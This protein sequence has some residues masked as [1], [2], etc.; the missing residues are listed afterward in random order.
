MRRIVLLIV[1]FLSFLG[2]SKAQDGGIYGSFV[3]ID[4]NYYQCKDGNNFNG[5][6]FG[7]FIEGSSLLL[8][9]GELKTWKKNQCDI[10]GAF[11]YY[12]IYKVG[13]TPSNFIEINLPWKQNGIDGNGNNQKWAKTDL[14]TNVLSGLSAGDYTIEVY[15]K[16]T[17][18]QGDKYDGNGGA[19]YKATLKV[20]APIP[21]SLQLT[22]PTP[23]KEDNLNNAV[24]NVILENE[25]FKDST[26]DKANFILEN[27][28]NGIT[29]KSV[30]YVDDKNAKVTLSF[31]GT[32]FDADVTNFGLTV[33]KEE[34][35]QNNTDLTKDNLTITAIVEDELKIG[36]VTI[37]PSKP[38]R[39]EQV[40]ITLDA[41]GTT[42]EDATKVYFHS[43]V[44]MDKPNSKQF[45]KVKG[46]WNND[47]G[48]GEMTSLGNHKWQIVLPSIDAY[49]SLTNNDD[50]FGLNFLFRNADGTKEKKNG[51]E[52]YHIEIEAGNYFIVTEPTSSPH[53]VEKGVSFPIKANA[54]KP[55]NWTLDEL[56]S[57]GT[58]K[59]ANVNTQ[60]NIEDYTFNHS[61]NDENVVHYFKL[62]ADFG[63]G[64]TK[65][66]TFEVKTHKAITVAPLPNGAKKGVNYNDDGT[67][68]F[69]LHTPTKT[70]YGYYGYNGNS[71]TADSSV[72]MTKAKKVVYLIGDFNNWTANDTY[73][74]NRTEDSDYWHI[75]LTKEQLKNLR[76]TGNKQSVFQYL[77]DGDIRIGDPYTHQ[78]SDYDDKYIIEKGI[79]PDLISYPEGKTTGRASVV[80]LENPTDYV[81]K[82]PVFERKKERNELNVYEL[83]FRD[84][85][86]EGTYKSAIAKLDYLKELGIN[87]IHVMPISEFEGNDSWG[88]NPN[89]YF[90][91]DKAYGTPND[92]KEF[93]D[94]AHQRGIAV[95]NDLVLNHAFSSNPN[96]MLYWNK[97]ENR[98]A[99]DNPWFN[100]QHKGIPNEGGHW[101]ADWNHGSEHTR[102]MVDDI[103]NYWMNEFHFD[104]FRFDFTKGLTQRDPNISGDWG[105]NYDAC[106]IEILKRMANVV[107]ANT[108]GTG[109]NPYVIFEHLAND[110]EDKE[111]ADA[112][113]LLWSGARTQT[114]YMEMAMG[115][116]IESFWNSVYKSREFNFAN[117]MSYLE[118]H[119]EERIGYKVKKW[120][121]NNDGTTKYLINRLKLVATFNMLLPGPRM[122]WQF[123]ELGYDKSIDENGRTGKKTNAWDLNYD[124][125]A[126]RQQLY[127]LYSLIFKLRNDY[128]F[129]PTESEPQYDNIG[130]TTDWKRKMRFWAPVP[131]NPTL[132]KTVQIIPVGNFDT[133]NNATITPEYDPNLTG[134]WFKYNGDPAVDGTPYQVN[135]VSDTYDLKTNDPVYILTNADLIPPKI[136]PITKKVQTGVNTCYIVPD[137]SF[138]FVKDTYSQTENPPAG[139]ASDNDEV[140]LY[141]TSINGVEVT[142]K[143]TFS[144]MEVT[145][146][147]SLQGKE[148][149]QGK[150]TI[151]WVAMDNFGNKTEVDQIIN[152]CPTSDLIIS[153]YVEPKKGRDKLVEIYNGTCEDI[154]LSNYKLGIYK[155]GNVADAKLESLSG[156]ISSGEFKVF[157]YT[158]P[159]SYTGVF[160][161]LGNK[162]NFNGNDPIVLLK[163]DVIID[164]LGITDGSDFAKD[165]T[166]R[167]KNSVTTPTVTYNADEWVKLTNTDDKIHTENI[168]K[169]TPLLHAINDGKP[170]CKGASVT[171]TA[172]GL[173]QYEFYINGEKQE[174]ASTTATFTTTELK[175]N[176]NV[177]VKLKKGTCEYTDEGITIEVE[178][179]TPK[180]TANKTTICP[181]EE[182]TFTAEGG[183][184]YEF[185]V[186]GV[187]QAKSTKNIFKS[188]TL[189]NGQKVKVKV[190]NDLGCSEESEEVTINV[191]EINADLQATK[192]EICP[193]EEVT[194][195]A[196]GGTEY[197]FFV[198][199]KSVQTK[200]TTNTFVTTSLTN[201]QKVKAVVYKDNCSK[202]TNVIAIKVNELPNNSG[203]GGFKDSEICQ[204]DDAIL[205]FDAIDGSF[206]TPYIIKYK[207]KDSTTE[208]TQEITDKGKV[209][210]TVPVKPTKTTVYE[211]V[212]IS[213]ATCTRTTDFGTAEATITVIAPADAGTDGTLTI[214]KGTT[215][216]DDELFNALGG[217]PNTGGDWTHNGNVYTYTVTAKSPCT[218]NATA[219]V[220]ITEVEKANAGTDVVLPICEGETPT[221]EELFKALGNPT[222]GGMWEHKGNKHTYTVKGTAPCGDATATVTVEENKLPNNGKTAGFKGK[223]ICQGDDAI[224]TFD[225]IDGSFTTPYI[226]KYKAKDSTTEWIQEI[227]DKGK[228]SIVVPEKPMK[229]TTY[230]LVSISN[231][232]CTRTAGFGKAT[233]EVEVMQP[234]NAGTN[235]TLTICKGTTP[236][237]EQ[238]FNALGGTPDKNGNWISN[239]NV[240]TYT[241]KSK[242]PCTADAT[243][244]V[245][246][247]EVAQANAGTDTTL[248]I[249]EGET[250]TEEDLFK[251]LKGNPTQGG[252]WEH[253]GAK[254]I[255]TVKGTSPCGDAKAIVTVKVND[256][257]NNSGSG[258]FK[259]SEICQGD[260][261]ILTFDA[262]D[263]SFTTPYIIKYKVQGSTTEWTQEI[264]N[265]GKVS[266]TVP[267]KPTKTTVYELV[268]ISNATC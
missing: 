205:T 189:T 32:D 145:G 204:G 194:F 48:I 176:D 180:I 9:G 193:N 8:K 143:T 203:S 68:T 130:S 60:S 88:Y 57:D 91:M 264:A 217:T 175:N 29:I 190:Y 163:N 256:L 251:A 210:I 52:N 116:K 220:T 101:G 207:A 7:S 246:I 71:C 31:D 43:G 41:T 70:T 30:T 252:T 225:A 19:N 261:A 248:T 90:A 212:S 249:C 241:V 230:E 42:L 188:T 150:N 50:A 131:S 265:K 260:D 105:S 159:E 156:I 153:E 157:S 46:T 20:T 140:Y 26:L 66:K 45:N 1:V 83:H 169:P 172:N 233:A 128:K 14:A 181:K 199:D 244:M 239:G 111:L 92:L 117:Y 218:P 184:A 257:P 250:P 213:N 227:T 135:S 16:A 177:T 224:L 232:T 6:N 263:D 39:T 80:Y 113:I 236:T 67:V 182:V 15:F 158:D 127:R 266:I 124:K 108:T 170:I 61:L 59:T 17:S 40:T 97:A 103:I 174:N 154:D 25:T 98:P 81:W 115:T 33:K 126:E 86:A 268:S 51:K 226:I 106:R 209:S 47:D 137:T 23:L 78:V 121:K 235:G 162:L 34:L 144:G 152:V 44:G 146:A 11:L 206:T 24:V 82:V 122:V 85:T 229:K 49:Y 219:I 253:K 201:K 171:F 10:T 155:D 56:N 64:V 166:L 142:E 211:L 160:E 12:R 69:V 178:E 94:E 228:V 114:P 200:S 74:L 133:E 76:L 21:A 129:Y 58:V 149:Q 107:W 222:V 3:I 231:A 109:K 110:A 100:P 196:T 165:V 237:N 168:G 96:L 22:V 75:T 84:F 197:E 53:L 245:T 216:T 183:T 191:T 104:G 35:K 147:K 36:N 262:I 87:C 123:G 187:A 223:S 202:E 221:E 214:C 72:G 27:A 167:R 125:D 65:T 151:H 77:V 139:K 37:S 38:T 192:Q 18:N 208:W 2:V 148:L 138:D 242:S 243:A 259:D 267:E 13:A 247:T 255:Y 258:G 195:T 102:Q 120:G 62:T 173:G 238:L 141:Y 93:I 136:T 198:D 79:Y 4:S 185:L 112:G 73:L 5:H 186:D 95:V 28:P 234:A 54:N 164:M 132:K 254:H 161:K 215:P 240:H 55:V 63:N 118:S 119:D 89:Y 134:K 179:I 99:N